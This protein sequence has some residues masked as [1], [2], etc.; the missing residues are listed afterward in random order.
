[1]MK[2]ISVYGLCLALVFPCMS[3]AADE[4][5]HPLKAFIQTNASS[6]DKVTE[7]QSSAAKRWGKVLLGSAIGALAGAAHARATGGDV[8]EQAAIGALAGGAVA[9]AITKIRDKR[10]ASRDE[11]AAMVSYEP[12]QGYRSGV[13]EVTV[14][15]DT[16]RAGETITVTV[17]YWALGP[18]ASETINMS[19]Y[20]GIAISGAYLRG[21]A[22]KPDPM[23][24]GEGGGQ[25]ET[26]IEIQLPKEVSPGTYS[27][28][29]L[30][31]GYSVSAD[32]EATFT[33]SG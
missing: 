7:V 30:L 17:S 32:K 3:M 31:D 11:V 21:F 29:W 12:A 5:T 19:R 22:F 18:A 24:F 14:S 1:M 28:G 6:P 2:K 33:V 25:F 13:P 4:A 10:L 8:G 16:V 23:K 26:T 15:P 9:F 27:I 20:A